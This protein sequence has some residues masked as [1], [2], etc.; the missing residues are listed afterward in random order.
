MPKTKALP[1]TLHA[2]E[3]LHI[4]KQAGF[5][6]REGAR[7]IHPITR[8]V[9]MMHSGGREIDAAQTIRKLFDIKAR[10]A[11]KLAEKPI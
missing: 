2:K 1:K 9:F 3:A 10:Y 7:H 8:E 4:L 11:R 5:E 6:Q